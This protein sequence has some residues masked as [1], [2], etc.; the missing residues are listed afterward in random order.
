MMY[1]DVENELGGELRQSF[2]NL[3]YFRLH[4]LKKEVTNT[5][6]CRLKCINV[7]K[8]IPAKMFKVYDSTDEK[9]NISLNNYYKQP[10][11]MKDCLKI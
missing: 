10:I 9:V 6:E 3:H 8:V 1:F 4:I 5:N 11:M 2:E 7:K